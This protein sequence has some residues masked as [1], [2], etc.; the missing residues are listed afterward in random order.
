MKEE[1]VLQVIDK[2]T[3][4][5]IT[6]EELDE[7]KPLIGTEDFTE[8]YRIVE[9]ME[10]VLQPT[11]RAELKKELEAAAANYHEEVKVGKLRSI[12]RF[13]LPA[14]AASVAICFATSIVHVITDYNNPK[15][16]RKTYI[17]NIK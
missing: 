8:T 11:G 13:A 15:N 12:N 9:A 2:L 14:I 4:A 17:E 7:L 1:D 6:L 10:T 3:N 16:Y 5:R